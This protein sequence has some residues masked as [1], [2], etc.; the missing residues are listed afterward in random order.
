MEG[1]TK[2]TNNQIAKLVEIPILSYTILRDKII[3]DFKKRQLR[4]IGFFGVEESIDTVR[5]FV[6]LSEDSKHLIHISSAHLDKNSSY[7]SITKEISSFHMYERDFYEE[8]G[9]KID[10]HPWLKG[11]NFRTGR[12]N[13]E[14]CMENYP[15]FKMDGESLH[16]VA[17]GP[18][19]A[20][21][22]EPGHFRFL[23][24][25]EQVYHLEIQLG[26][27]HRNIENLFLERNLKFMPHL[28]E[29][30][31]GDTVIGHNLACLNLIEALTQTIIP[32]RA[33]LIRT[34]ALEMERAAIHLADLSA[35]ANDIGYLMGSSVFGV[36]R[37]IIINTLL[38]ICGNRFGRGLMRPGGCVFDIH[39][40]LTEKI[41]TNLSKVKEDTIRMAE[42]MFK[43]HTVASR[44]ENTGILTKEEAISIGAVGMT[45]RASSYNVDARHSHPFGFYKKLLLGEKTHKKGDVHSRAYLRYEEIIESIEIVFTLLN[46]LEDKKT[47]TQIMTKIKDKFQPSSL[48]VSIVEG[49]RGEIIHCAITNNE[50][51]LLKYKIKD[52]S[53]TN[54]FA[55]ALAVRNNGISD[56]PL[57]NKSFNLSYCGNDL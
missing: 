24:N 3:A 20:G 56:F 51:D 57:C 30:I 55:L 38:L 48:V 39:K 33:I 29:S 21:V 16:E 47:G 50:G 14:S 37:T 6:L 49:W 17:V 42:T 18:I 15:F 9:I 13:E 53:L 12:A 27:Q 25:G 36:T 26:Y 23:C 41:R 4:C 22:I 52:P 7:E 34:I 45:A 11:V 10:G 8:F 35:L 40:A 54:W 5:L 32:D 2:I 31:A 19:H 1:F 44:F 46:E 43:S 28:A